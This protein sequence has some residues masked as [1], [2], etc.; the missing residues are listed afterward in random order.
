M[1]TRPPPCEVSVV[2]VNHNGREW[3]R[4]CLESVRAALAATDAAAEVIVIDNASTDGSRDM[5]KDAFADVRVIAAET[6]VGF[7]GGAQ[8]AIDESAGD[9]LFFVNNDAVVGRSAIAALLAEARRHADVGALAAQMRFAQR[10]EVVNSAGIEIDRLGSA[11]DVGLGTSAA[12]L[13]QAPTEIFGASAGAALYRRAMLDQVGGFDASFF[14]YLEDADLAWRARA[15]GWRCL[16][17]PGAVV[18]HEHSRSAGHRS[19]FKYF[20]VGR[21]RMRMLAKNATAGHLA[22]YWPAIALYDLAYV[23]YALAVDR[24]TAPLR[25]RVAGLREWRRYR[26]RGRPRRP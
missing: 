7:A 6:N 10:P 25:G 16:Q 3:L 2:V 20:L 15:R 23:S 21:N 8:I 19:D 4:P 24:S 17:V 5:L 12:C 1:T 26:V 14:M 22:R 18:L 11:I 9:W 13:P